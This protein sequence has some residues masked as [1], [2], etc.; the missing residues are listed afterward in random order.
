TMNDLASKAEAVRV[1]NLQ[2][3]DE[4]LHL[5][6]ENADLFHR[7]I[8][9]EQKVKDLE[10][11][12]ESLRLTT[13][14]RSQHALSL[15][16]NSRLKGERDALAVRLLHL[17]SFLEQQRTQGVSSTERNE[18]LAKENGELKA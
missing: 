7:A 15:D 2:L 17:E 18:V 10:R 5:V 8:E 13:V 4:N 11:D 12:L 3:V 1:Q 16:Q 6:D 9:A 14:D